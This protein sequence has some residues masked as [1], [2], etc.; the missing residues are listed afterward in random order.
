MR[1]ADEEA[2][3]RGKGNIKVNTHPQSRTKRRVSRHWI[4]GE[5]MRAGCWTRAYRKL[6]WLSD[7]RRLQSSLQALLSPVPAPILSPLV[8]SSHG[9]SKRELARRLPSNSLFLCIP[10]EH[11]RRF[12]HVLRSP[13]PRESQ[14]RWRRGNL[15]LLLRYRAQWPLWDHDVFL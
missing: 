8:L 4:E 7:S 3:V 9:W 10:D 5:R 2:Q 1:A 12:H 6:P 15:S 14:L 11:Q 13:S